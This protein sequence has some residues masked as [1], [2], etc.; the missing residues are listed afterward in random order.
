VCVCVC[1]CAYLYVRACTRFLLKN[2]VSLNFEAHIP[3]TSTLTVIRPANFMW[4]LN[5]H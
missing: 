2:L 1:V 5:V 4:K 3:V